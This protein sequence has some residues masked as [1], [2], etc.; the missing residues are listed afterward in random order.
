[1][2][3]ALLLPGYLE[4]P[5]YQHLLVIDT[6]LSSLGY[7]VLRID[8]CLLWSTGIEQK[9]TLTN[10]IKQVEEIIES[11]RQYDLEDVVL[12][13]HSLGASTA[14]LVGVRSDIVTKVICLSPSLVLEKSRNKWG[15]DGVRLSKKDL[16]DNPSV[17]R[18][19]SIPLSHY[20]DRK[21]YSVIDALG[22]F[23]K[24]MMFLFGL[25]DPLVGEI[26]RLVSE[27][28]IS[29]VVRIENMNH[30]FRQ[31]PE[32]CDIVANEVEKFL[33]DF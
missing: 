31:S 20:E 9:Y 21:K 22:D 23:K 17:Y 27:I 18:D 32:L 29:K 24:P 11:Y 13:G 3:L 10:Y 16:P 6:K 33:A 19:F 26:E 15:E 28:E 8:P 1:M 5:E 14:I 12:V 25:K 7:K 30:D 2:K 4:S